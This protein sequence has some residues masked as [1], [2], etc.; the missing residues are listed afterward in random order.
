MPS[1]TPRVMREGMR[2]DYNQV[3]A[4][5]LQVYDRVRRAEAIR[6]TSPNGT[7][8]TARFSPELNWVASHGLYHEEGDWGNLPEGEVFTCPAAVEGT[9]VAEVLGD[10]FSP[11]YGILE[12]PVTFHLV[13]GWVKKVE[14][15]D[16]TLR[17][18]VWGYLSSDEF[19][20]RTGEF[21]IGTN[22]A[23][24]QLTGNLLQDEKLP[25]VHVAFGSPYAQRTGADWSASVH[26]DVV[27]TECTIE[28]DGEVI[29]TDGRFQL[30]KEQVA[31]A[32]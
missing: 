7:D 28:V 21:A 25:G 17:S 30:P 5:T 10:Y 8:L 6:V 1:I 26:V 20:R 9:I 16:Q 32:G 13:D 29:M 14:C 15:I 18:E 3:H 12:H 23:I 22:T 19:G 2:A 27:P 31:S 11:K 4:L 24:S